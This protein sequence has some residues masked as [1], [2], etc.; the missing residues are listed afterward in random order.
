MLGLCFRERRA[1]RPCDTPVAEPG[2]FRYGNLAVGC[3]VI[4]LT[5]LT[6]MYLVLFTV[7]ND[8]IY[9]VNHLYDSNRT[10]GVEHYHGMTAPPRPS[11][12]LGL[13]PR[14]YDRITAVPP[15]HDS[16]LPL[17]NTVGSS[18]ARSML[19]GAKGPGALRYPSRGAQGVPIWKFSSRMLCYP[20]DTSDSNVPCTFHS[21]Q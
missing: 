14:A 17:I 12:A 8:Q 5:L 13:R 11:V 21:L 19:Q 3:C 4:H 15:S 20:P 16:A 1:R 2:G 18:Y 7:F 9:L 6:V 10:L